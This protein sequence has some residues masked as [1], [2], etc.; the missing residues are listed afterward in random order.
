MTSSIMTSLKRDDNFIK[1]Y[2]LVAKY[3]MTSSLKKRQQI[4]AQ[5]CEGPKT[6]FQ[7]YC[8][9]ETM[10]HAIFHHLIIL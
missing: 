8:V 5:H 10:I 9:A 4:I 2:N 1:K 3:R 6:F 7:N